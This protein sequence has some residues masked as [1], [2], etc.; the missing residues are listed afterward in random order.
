MAVREARGGSGKDSLL[1]KVELV[2]TFFSFSSLLLPPLSVLSFLLRYFFQ[3]LL[4]LL[5]LLVLKM[6][7]RTSSPKSDKYPTIE[8]HFPA[9][10]AS[11]MCSIGKEGT[12]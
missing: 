12:A 10:Q 1:S 6:E 3:C 11:S 5:S 2:L 9:W 8:L 7:P 4:L